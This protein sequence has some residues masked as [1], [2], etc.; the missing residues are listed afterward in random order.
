MKCKKARNKLSAYI[1]DRLG[2]EEEE[3]LKNHLEGCT[4]CKSYLVH[5]K[6]LRNIFVS[7]RDDI[8]RIDLWLSLKNRLPTERRW[9]AWEDVW[10]RLNRKLSWASLGGGVALALSI[11]MVS[12]FATESDRGD[13][14]LQV[15]AS[16]VVEGE[17][18]IIAEDNPAKDLFIEAWQASSK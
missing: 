16:N 14:Y 3:Y 5:L 13:S 8:P 17:A 12:F 15:W 1:D 18:I 11:L 10:L 9:I 2:K 6:N 4:S 7:A